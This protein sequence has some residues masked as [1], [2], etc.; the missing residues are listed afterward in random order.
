M[1][2]WFEN[3]FIGNTIFYGFAILC[4]LYLF[5]LIDPFYLIF[6]IFSVAASFWVV[7]ILVI[8]FLKSLF[9]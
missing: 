9:R 6:Y 4:V 5:D 8:W 3:S 1:L 2:N 7:V